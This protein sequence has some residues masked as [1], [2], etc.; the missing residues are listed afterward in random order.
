MKVKP[1]KAPGGVLMELGPKD[2]KILEPGAASETAARLFRIQKILVPVDFSGC[3]EKALQYAIPFAG[4]FGA[5]IVLLHVLQL[6]YIAG[7]E[8]GGVDF[9][10]LESEMRQNS[11]KQLAALGTRVIGSKAPASTLVRAGRPVGEIVATARE[12]EVD[13]IIMSTHGHTGLKHV[14]LGST[15]E[16]VVR[17]APCPVLV[18]RQDEHEFVST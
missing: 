14:L 8:F 2:S 11:E 13:L 6:N 15:T 3:S 5:A 16:N 10:L 17:Y 9:P 4:Q 7:S 1:S 12:L 18:V